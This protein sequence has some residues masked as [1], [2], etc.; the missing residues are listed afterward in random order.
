MDGQ[1][2]VMDELETT[3][4]SRSDLHFAVIAIIVLTARA[5]SGDHE[6]CIEVGTAIT[7]PK[8]SACWDL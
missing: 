5:I 8:Q 4:R 6:W 7:C 1:M 2:Q 3:R